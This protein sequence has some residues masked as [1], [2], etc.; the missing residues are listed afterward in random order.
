MHWPK[1]C[2]KKFKKVNNL[3]RK[4]LT[5]WGPNKN[6][7]KKSSLIPILPQI[8][9]THK[10]WFETKG[11]HGIRADL[12]EEDLREGNFQKCTLVEANLQAAD[13]G[14]A[15]FTDADLRG[16]NLQEAHLKGAILVN[17][18]FEETDLMWANLQGANLENTRL[19]GAYLH[20]ANLK[21]TGISLS[22]IKLAYTDEDTQLPEGF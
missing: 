17:A 9:S 10:E 7:V 2:I 19:D 20:G 22:Q 16:A 18:N 6:I 1:H 11:Q 21:D 14:N 5:F 8:L 13:L 3:T 12:S 4:N 15:D